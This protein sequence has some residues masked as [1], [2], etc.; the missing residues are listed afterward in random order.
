[1]ACLSCIQE[2]EDLNLC[3]RLTVVSQDFRGF[4]QFLSDITFN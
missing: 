4:L 1:M 3:R 2:V